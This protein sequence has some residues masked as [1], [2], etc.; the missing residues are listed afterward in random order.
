MSA[1]ATIQSATLGPED[2]LSLVLFNHMAGQF[3]AL[4]KMDDPGRQRANEQL[5]SI[6]AGGGTNIW[7]G[8]EQGVNSLKADQMG[9]RMAHVMLMTN[10]QTTNRGTLMSN[11][12]EYRQKHQQLPRARLALVA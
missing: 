4:T 1:E 12:A 9:G 6:D 8:L 7:L 5:D 11:V 3:F 2:R 10:G